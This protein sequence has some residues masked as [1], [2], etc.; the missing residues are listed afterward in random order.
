VN[1]DDDDGGTGSKLKDMDEF[2]KIKIV[3]LWDR[4]INFSISSQYVECFKAYKGLYHFIEPYNF[5]SKPYLIE[6]IDLLQNYIRGMGD[7]PVNVRDTLIFNQKKFM[8]RDLLDIFMSELPK[9]FVEL[10]L[11]LKS[12]PDYNDFDSKF[13]SETFG[14]ETSFLNLKREGLKKLKTVVIVDLMSINAVSDVYAK[15][16]RLNVL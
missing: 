16:R 9:A 10:D 11:W 2:L 13:S 7:K 6:L 14:D 15:A 1:K 8:F 12:V 4:A 3:D 5:T